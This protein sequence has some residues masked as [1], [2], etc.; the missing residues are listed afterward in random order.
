[1]RWF[2]R[3]EAQADT[4]GIEEQIA[5]LERAQHSLKLRL[6]ELDLHMTEVHGFAKR[7][8]GRVIATEARNRPKENDEDAPASTISEAVRPETFG[9]GVVP[10]SVRRRLS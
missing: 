8:M 7:A 5:V 10:P 6:D 4:K 2:R 1:M 9:R 3:T